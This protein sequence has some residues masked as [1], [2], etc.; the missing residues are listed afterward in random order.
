MSLPRIGA[1]TVIAF[2]ILATLIVLL[3][4]GHTVGWNATWRSVGVTPLLPPFF[5]AHVVLDYAACASKGID[6]YHPH[7]CNPDNFNIPPIWLW[8]GRIAVDENA[9]WF[10]CAMAAAAAAAI[11]ALFRGRSGADGAIALIAIFSPSVFMG[12]ERG[13]TDLLIFAITGAAAVTYNTQRNGR[14]VGTIAL[15]TSAVVLKLFP[16]FT[17]ALAIRCNRRDLLYAIAVST[18]SL[19]YSIAILKYIFLIRANVPGTF[20]LSYGYKA[21]FFGLDHL[22]S[23][24]GLPEL[25]LAAAWL[26]ILLTASAL[27]CGAAAALIN[28]RYSWASCKVAINEAGTAF[29]FGSSI[30]C[31][32]FLL[33]TN[34]IYR[35]IFLLLCL[36]QLRDWC[37]QETG[38]KRQTA[39]WLFVTVLA[40]LWLNG[41]AN[42]HTTFLIMPQL[43]NWLLFSELSAVLIWNALGNVRSSILRSD[44]AD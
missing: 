23:E 38:T 36:P 13:N 20:M 32:T 24:A 10:S 28:L 39:W 44:A 6:P 31:G 42:G 27:G 12:I 43:F 18:L 26:P 19:V 8:L 16:M 14:L 30:Y 9:A 33:G 34:F 22:R 2:G 40:V 17:V 29:I 7:A 4:L 41:I 21:I 35:L 25:G 15:T 11:I 5:D 3:F 37:R 1:A